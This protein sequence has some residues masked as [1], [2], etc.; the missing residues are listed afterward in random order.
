MRINAFA[1]GCPAF[2]QVATAS[3]CIAT[4][5][6]GAS[7]SAETPSRARRFGSFGS[8]A[9]ARGRGVQGTFTN[10]GPCQPTKSPLR[11]DSARSAIMRATNEP[12]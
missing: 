3:S 1:S 11:S 8:P 6:A 4:R 9:D 5:A 2:V 7:S 10:A 12:T